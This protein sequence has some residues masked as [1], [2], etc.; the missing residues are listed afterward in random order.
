VLDSQGSS[1]PGSV[2]TC[3][4]SAVGHSV[5]YTF[6]NRHR[7]ST[8]SIIHCTH[9]VPCSLGQRSLAVA[10][11]WATVF[12]ISS[13]THCRSPT[14]LVMHCI[15]EVSRSPGQR[16]LAAMAPWATLFITPSTT[17]C[18]TFMPK[19]AYHMPRQ[20]HRDLSI[21]RGHCGNIFKAR[22]L[23]QQPSEYC[24]T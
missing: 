16:L 4:G 10:V 6:D 18:C 13:T 23:G 14:L 5:Y 7:P 1:F 22:R 17:H 2:V 3:H 11:P 15:H 19:T 12:I 21:M 20:R 24:Y 9:E 8:L